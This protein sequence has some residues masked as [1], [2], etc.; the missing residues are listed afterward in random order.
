MTADLELRHIPSSVLVGRALNPAELC[1][2]RCVVVVDIEWKLDYKL[3]FKACTRDR[4]SARLTFEEFV[5]FMPVHDGV[6]GE[7]RPGIG[8]DSRFDLSQ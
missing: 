7:E 3:W 6:E 2:I 8:L 5:P 4:G 1:L